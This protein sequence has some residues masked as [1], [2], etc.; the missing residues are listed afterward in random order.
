MDRQRLQLL[1]AKAVKIV[2]EMKQTKITWHFWIRFFDVNALN[3]RWNA[4]QALFVDNLR[5]LVN[6]QPRFCVQ[7]KRNFR[8]DEFVVIVIFQVAHAHAS[9]NGFQTGGSVRKGV[10]P[11]GLNCAVEE[12]CFTNKWNLTI[13]LV[14]QIP[15]RKNLLKLFLGNFVFSSLE[16]LLCPN[17][18]LATICIM[19]QATQCLQ[20]N[21]WQ[22]TGW[23][24]IENNAKMI[25]AIAFFPNK[26]ESS[27][28]RFN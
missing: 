28:A 11:S 4:W 10:K 2:T 18:C 24:T 1:K 25:V 23:K 27:S 7:S 9:W 16:V 13:I 5:S 12:E 8:R 21:D 6:P 22:S 26:I 15:L 3:W 20:H 19:L 14:T 17:R